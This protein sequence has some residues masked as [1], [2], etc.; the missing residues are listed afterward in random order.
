MVLLFC[1]LIYV[2]RH[3]AAQSLAESHDV[4]K[5]PKN[6]SSEAAATTSNYNR[7]G[8]TEENPKENMLQTGKHNPAS[9]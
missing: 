2:R 5:T 8:F 1:F 3:K 4:I 7:P 6:I 9:N